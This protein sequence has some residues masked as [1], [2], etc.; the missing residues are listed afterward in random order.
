MIFAAWGV[1]AVM[2][3]P[4]IIA[5]PYIEG[6]RTVPPNDC[7]IQFIYSNEYMSIITI[8][9]AFFLPV[10]ASFS[11]IVG[12][13]FQSFEHGKAVVVFNQIVFVPVSKFNFPSPPPCRSP[14]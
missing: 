14:S 8:I 7:Y 11:T 6:R 4:W 2:W 13:G 5:W 12:V 10:R 1:S 3:P 9:I